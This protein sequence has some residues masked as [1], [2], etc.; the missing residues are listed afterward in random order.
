MQPNDYFFYLLQKLQWL[1]SDEWNIASFYNIHQS[2]YI[3][4]YEYRLQSCIEFIYRCLKCD[5]IS[6]AFEIKED[7][8]I[9]NQLNIPE[10]FAR[11]M[12]EL[13]Y[14]TELNLNKSDSKLQDMIWEWSYVVATPKLVTISDKCGLNRGVYTVEM[15]DMSDKKWVQFYVEI[16]RVFTENS[17]SWD[18][19][20]PLFSIV[21]T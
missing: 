8:F 7:L 5:L 21:P 6:C 9:E 11:K 16:N 13:P 15:I 17:L 12:G 20:H 10:N 4:N 3:G 18:M 19:K 14:Y 1:T 2:D